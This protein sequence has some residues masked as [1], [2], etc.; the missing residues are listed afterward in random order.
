MVVVNAD[1]FTLFHTY[2]CACKLFRMQ[3]S[4]THIHTH[5]RKHQRTI[6]GCEWLRATYRFSHLHHYHHCSLS[7]QSAHPKT[8][9]RKSL[10]GHQTLADSDG[11]T[12]SKNKV[13]CTAH[14][15]QLP[16]LEAKAVLLGHCSHTNGAWH[17][18]ERI[19]SCLD[20]LAT[21]SFQLSES[22]QL[23]DHNSKCVLGHTSPT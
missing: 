10:L 1:K 3:N 11:R 14:T 23:R 4:I 21:A 5:V 7:D 17:D 15:K 12:N 16:N 22:L 20:L 18:C 9:H 8:E 2:A 19:A 13:V 6:V